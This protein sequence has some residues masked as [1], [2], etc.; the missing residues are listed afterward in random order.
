MINGP[1]RLPKLSFKRGIE[2]TEV[3]PRLQKQPVE[4]IC[5][6]LRRGR[7]IVE[8]GTTVNRNVKTPCKYAVFFEWYDRHAEDPGF[9]IRVIRGLE[10]SC[11]RYS[12][13][14]RECWTGLTGLTRF[15]L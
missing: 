11:N 6:D 3:G 14:R 13:I 10:V 2:R 5:F 9:G 8:G 7:M 4:I 12:K 15:D 1:E